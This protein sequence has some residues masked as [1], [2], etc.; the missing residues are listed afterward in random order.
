MTTAGGIAV[1]DPRAGAGMTMAPE[2]V[3][4]IELGTDWADPPGD[5]PGRRPGRRWR[6]PAACLLLAALLAGAAG[7]ATAPA[8]RLIQVARWDQ[9]NAVVAMAGEDTVLVAGDGQLA[10]YDAYDGRPLWTATAGGVFGWTQAAGEGVQLVAFVRSTSADVASMLPSYDVL[11][12]ERRTG[13]VRWRHPGLVDPVAGVLVNRTG[14]VAHPDVA[15]HDPDTFALR[16][17]APEG[18]AAGIDAWGSALWRL[19]DG[20]DLVEHDL[21]TGAVRRDLRV[22]APPT[23]LIEVVPT[24]HAIG[25][26]GY[27]RRADGVPELVEHWYDRASLRPASGEGRWRWE[28]DCGGGLSCAGTGRD[29]TAYLLDSAT[30]APVRQLPSRLYLGSPA[31]AL[32]LDENDRGFAARLDPATGERLTD[33]RGW[34][35]PATMSTFIRFVGRFDRASRTTYLAAL[36][37]GGLRPLGR[38]A[39]AARRC[40]AGPGVLVCATTGGEVVIWRIAEG[41]A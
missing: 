20:G 22:P 16:W 10:A 28:T 2:A 13:A 9:P 27:R 24:R 14:D 11:A 25:L 4:V 18:R 37:P 31:G 6:W 5:L 39:L 29:D 33:V 15:V 23:E 36:T 32:L 17:R 26:S 41:A 40:E 12:V 1:R 35:V 30:G 34:T 21:A 3:T 38:V 19:T 7:D 8:P